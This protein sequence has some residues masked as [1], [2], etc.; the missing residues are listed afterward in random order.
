MI[1]PKPFIAVTEIL[2]LLVLLIPVITRSYDGENDG[3]PAQT[4]ASDRP[5]RNVAGMD[6]F[7]EA[8]QPVLNAEMQGDFK[9]VSDSVPA[10]SNAVVKLSRADLPPFHKDVAREFGDKRFELV[11]AV[12]ELDAARG[13]D[14]KT[15]A[16]ALENVRRKFIELMNILSVRLDEIDR[17]HEILRPLWHEAVPNQDY[18][19]IKSAIP[20]LNKAMNALMQAKLPAKYSFLESDF[21]KKRD[22]LKVSVDE[23]AK[24]CKNGNNQD[25]EE[26]MINMHEAYH[27][28]V[29]C[30]E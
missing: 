26:K 21:I 23:L 25:I 5:E 15:I 17:F 16:A 6:D 9:T 7:L 13:S 12:T 11:M 28:L 18:E 22:I 24:T 20:D 3:N 29:E 2:L 30:L 14:R 27:G 8:L 1:K 19:T 10:L 4:A